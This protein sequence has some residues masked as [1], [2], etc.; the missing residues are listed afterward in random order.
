MMSMAIAMASMLPASGAELVPEWC[1]IGDRPFVHPLEFVSFTFTP[2]LTLTGMENA[3]VKCGNDIVASSTGFEV[4]LLDCDHGQ[5]SVIIYFEKQNLPLGKDYTLVVS[6][7]SFRFWDEGEQVNDCIE[8]PFMVPADLGDIS[9][10]SIEPNQVVESRKSIWVYWGT[11]TEAVGEPEWTLYRNGEVEGTYPA[12]VGWDWDLGQAYVDFGD[13]KHFDRDVRYSLVLP[14]G[15]V[16]SCYRADIL[17]REVRI[18]FVGG[19]EDPGEPPLMWDWCSLYTLWPHDGILGDV[20]FRYNRPVSVVD[21]GKVLLYET[22]PERLVA[23]AD[24]YV[25]TSVNCF[26]V[27]A[28]FQGFQTDAMKGY[29]LVIPAGTVVA[30][31]GTGDENP[32][33]TFERGAQSGV[34]E[35]ESESDLESPVY[36]LYGRQVPNPLPG[37]IYI[38]DGRKIVWK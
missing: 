2:D 18:D 23:E 21:N 6:N 35:I 19:Y 31:D 10:A 16:S 20:W 24:A 4:A 30:E 36:D 37:S 11:E 7:G 26:V 5:S 25:D 15:S 17:N 27:R 28:D 8:V 13:K 3:F 12:H 22:E 34:S 33:Q 14:A 32:R 1:S 38:R 29:T 9:S